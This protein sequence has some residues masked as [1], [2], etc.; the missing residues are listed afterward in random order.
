[1]IVGFVILGVIAVGVKTDINP[2]LIGPS[3]LTKASL[4]GWQLVYI[5][6]VAIFTNVFFLSVSIA[7]FAAAVRF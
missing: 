2:D 3:G 4:L 1:M 6:P 5:L 7:R